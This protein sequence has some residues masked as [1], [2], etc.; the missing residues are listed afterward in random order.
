M[1]EVQVGSLT[2]AIEIEEILNLLR[3]EVCHTRFMGLSADPFSS[4]PGMLELGMFRHDV[5]LGV[6]GLP[7]LK[8][9][10]EIVPNSQTTA[11]CL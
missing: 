2:V 5:H 10:A 8:E 6:L 1:P 9:I 3:L 11:T 4:H 7:R